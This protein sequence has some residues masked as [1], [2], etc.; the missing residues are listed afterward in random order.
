MYI[1]SY[2][3]QRPKNGLFQKTKKSV[4]SVEDITGKFQRVCQI[5]GNKYG[6]LPGESTK[7]KKINE[8][9][10]WN[11]RGKLLFYNLFKNLI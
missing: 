3:Q 11:Y 6:Y 2:I 1:V 8:K 7:K 10:S 9:V 5:K 4:N